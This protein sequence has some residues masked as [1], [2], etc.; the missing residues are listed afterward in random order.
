[1]TGPRRTATRPAGGE[2]LINDRAAC[3]YCNRRID[4]EPNQPAPTVRQHT[5]VRGLLLRRKRHRESWV[6]MVDSRERVVCPGSG[7]IPKLRRDSGRS[8][9]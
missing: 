4:L 6:K 5:V 2:A 9:E 7:Q 1:M 3:R 8:L